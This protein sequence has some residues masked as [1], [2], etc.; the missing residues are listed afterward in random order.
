ML[1]GTQIS[2][3]AVSRQNSK[4]LHNGSSK[5]ASARSTVRSEISWY[6]NLLL[7]VNV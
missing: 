5:G 4:Q 1:R 2:I 6:S 3:E 7:I